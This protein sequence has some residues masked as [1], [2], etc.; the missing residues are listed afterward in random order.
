MTTADNFDHLLLTL[1]HESEL[2]VKWFTDN[3]MIVNRDKF[4]AMISQNSKNSKNYEPVKLEIETAKI[5]RKNTVELLGITIDNKLNFE[6]HVS[7]LC[8]KSLHAIKCSKSFTK[9]YG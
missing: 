9:I 2:G 8:K 7:E 3:R 5:E 6:E 1:K 4:Q